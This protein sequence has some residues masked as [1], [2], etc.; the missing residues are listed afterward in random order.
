MAGSTPVAG[1]R[2]GR[3]RLETLLGSG[4]M[5]TVWAATE[6]EGGKTV[7]LKVLNKALEDRPGPRQRLIREA[8]ASRMIEHDAIVPVH[9]VFEHQGSLVLV[10]DL[11][12]G[13][14]LRARLE[15]EGRL[16]AGV[17]ATLL[18]QVASALRAAHAAG[19]VHRDLKPENIFITRE[20]GADRVKV[21]DFGVAKVQATQP[22]AQ[23]IRTALGAL[24]GT[25]SYMAPEQVLGAGTVE[26]SADIW[27]LGTILYEAL[28]G[29]RP[30]EGLD[31]MDTIQRILTEAIVPLA[32]IAPDLP[33]GLTGLVDRMLSRAPEL[34]PSSEAVERALAEL[35][36]STG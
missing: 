1:T 31:E 28:A 24:L 23:E 12:V 34:R 14:T 13:E 25:V 21:L 2:I 19:V 15:R 4:G 35:G 22:P 10:M 17:A 9:E 7:A 26:A 36:V 32:A 20:E 5:G 11:L 16:S 27:G 30:I 33:G 6:A 18:G 29:S 8:R 3:F